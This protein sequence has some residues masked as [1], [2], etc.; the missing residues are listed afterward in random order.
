MDTKLSDGWSG[1]SRSDANWM[2][3]L[4]GVRGL[5]PSGASHPQ[6][7]IDPHWFSQNESKIHCWPPLVLPQ[8]DYWNHLRAIGKV[9]CE[10]GWSWTVIPWANILVEDRINKTEWSIVSNAQIQRHQKGQLLW[11]S[12]RLLCA[13]RMQLPFHDPPPHLRGWKLRTFLNSFLCL[14]ALRHAGWWAIV[15]DFDDYHQASDSHL[16]IS[17]FYECA[18]TDNR[19]G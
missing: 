2:L 14:L 13:D 3:D 15:S 6:V 19:T 8:I 17:F 4:S 9:W 1:R 11:P 12:S 7:N 10:P 16:V 18:T 5:T